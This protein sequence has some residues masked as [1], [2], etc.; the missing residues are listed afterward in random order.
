MNTKYTANGITHRVWVNSVREADGT[1]SLFVRDFRLIYK[2]NAIVTTLRRIGKRSTYTESTKTHV[3]DICN[4][5]EEVAWALGRRRAQVDAKYPDGRWLSSSFASVTMIEALRMWTKSADD[6][7]LTKKIE[8][9]CTENGTAE[10]FF[11]GNLTKAEFDERY[12]TLLG[13]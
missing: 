12:G 8:M 11:E 13:C 10:V 4:T 6:G 2:V 7:N 9:Y 5:V 3:L 1:T